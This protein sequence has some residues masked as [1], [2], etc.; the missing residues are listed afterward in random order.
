M[1]PAPT[2][3]HRKGL[4][5]VADVSYR[6]PRVVVLLWLLALVATTA[7]SQRFRADTTDR[8]RP[9]VAV[10]PGGSAAEPREQSGPASLGLG[11]IPAVLILLIA[12]GS[13]LARGLPTPTA[14]FGLGIGTALTALLANFVQV[15][16]F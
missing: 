10:E 1:A 3:V 14:I 16:D 11:L 4:L 9:G 8:R 15:P 5:R 2:T 6:R 13:P 12:F 7:L